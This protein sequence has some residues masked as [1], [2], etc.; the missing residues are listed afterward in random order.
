MINIIGTITIHF[1]DVTFSFLIAISIHLPRIN[2]FF[3]LFHVF[4]NR[5]K[6]YNAYNQKYARYNKS[7]NP[8][9]SNPKSTLSVS[10][11]IRIVNV[12]PTDLSE[13]IA[14]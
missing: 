6:H 9:V 2:F 13:E 3:R 11:S 5:Y 4:H 8:A 12:S 14:M 7:E 10:G 1:A